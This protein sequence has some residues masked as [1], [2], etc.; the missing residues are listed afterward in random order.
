MRLKNHS[1]VRT[2]WRSPLGRLDIAS[3]NQGLVGVWFEGAAH[4]PD[5]SIWPVVCTPVHRLAIEQLDAYFAGRIN[6]FRLPLDLS[7]GTPFQQSVWQ[8]LL[9]LPYGHTLSYSALSLRL[10]RQGALRAVANAI[11]HNPL[12]IIVP[13]HRVIGADGR[14]TGYA[15]GLERK[16]ALLRL[17]GSL[18]SL[19]PSA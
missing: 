16:A 3:S 13:C 2:Q 17:E 7:L 12:G 11:A 18:P 4:R 15:A 9:E 6:R 10:G 19:R 1:L 8:A 5:M 14:L